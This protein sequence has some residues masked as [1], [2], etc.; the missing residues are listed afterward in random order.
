MNRTALVT[1]MSRRAG[2]ATAVVERLLADGLNVMAS[3]WTPHDAEMPWGVDPLGGQRL[4]EELGGAGDLAY[5]E[6]DLSDPATPQRLVEASIKRFGRIDAV[7]AVHARSSEGGGL[8]SVTVEELDECWQVNTRG[9]LLLA[10]AFGAAFEGHDSPGRVVFFTS[11]Q[12]IEPMGNEL[13]YA[14]SKGAIQQMTASI[15]DQLIDKNITVNCVNPGPVDTG[16]AQGDGHSE[17]ARRFPSGRWGQPSDVANLVSFLVGS[18][19]GWITGQTLN[20]EGGFRR[21]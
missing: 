2:I 6:A 16:W 3:G 10:K 11:G 21:S 19:G 12:H 20:S 1:G 8:D 9:S 7:V 14:L 18:D 15:S 17:I 5:Q 13:A 4:A